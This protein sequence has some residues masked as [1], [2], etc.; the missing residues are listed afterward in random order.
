M[1]PGDLVVVMRLDHQGWVQGSD[2]AST[3]IARHADPGPFGGAAKLVGVWHVVRRQTQWFPA[4]PSRPSTTIWH[5]PLVRF[6]DD[7]AVD[8]SS[9]RA[10]DP[11]GVGAIAP[12]TTPNW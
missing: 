9:L 4:G 5:L 2:G 7:D 8:V 6:H 3:Y 12:F 11:Q 10:L 1:L